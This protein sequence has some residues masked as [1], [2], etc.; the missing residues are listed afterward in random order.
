M[1]TVWV[2]VAVVLD[3]LVALVGVLIP[4]RWLARYRPA[5]MGFAAGALLAAAVLDL[6][7]EALGHDGVGVLPWLLGSMVVLA[8]LEAVLGMHDH[9]AADHH[10]CGPRVMPYAILGSDALHNISDGMAIAAAFIH[11]TNLGVITSVAVI[12]HELPEELADYAILRA[13]GMARRRALAWNVAVQ[14]TAVLGAAA[15][16]VGVSLAGIEGR[17][18][19]IAAGS[20]LY[21]ALFELLPD[22]VR[23][24]TR[25]QAIVAMV[26]GIAA[27]ATCSA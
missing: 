24:G 6:V 23:A 3:G 27:I 12:V 25:V 13:S 16:L 9:H 15:V 20:F 7:P 18:L 19:A 4:E 11:S 1:T 5:L 10:A 21:I 2:A 8:L 14:L 26:I 22:V 17:V